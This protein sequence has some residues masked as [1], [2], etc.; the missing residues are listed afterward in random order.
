MHSTTKTKA[1][2]TQAIDRLTAWA[3]EALAQYGAE[4]ASGGGEPPFPQAAQDVLDVCAIAREAID[5]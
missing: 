1:D 4:T 5:R 3:K 2:T